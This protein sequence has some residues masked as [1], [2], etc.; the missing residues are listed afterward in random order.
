MSHA[1][2]MEKP[3]TS[4]RP[5]S[6]RV[7]YSLVVPADHGWMAPPPSEA[8]P[9]GTTSSGSTSLRVPSPVHSGQAPNGELKENDRGSSSSSASGWS[10][11]QAS[12]SE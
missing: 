7:K 12:R 6:S 4:A 5:C 11:G 3:I 9:S 2:S 10:F 8:A 1:V